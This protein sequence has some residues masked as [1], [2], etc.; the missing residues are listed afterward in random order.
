MGA[1]PPPDVSTES[2]T[3][4]Q[5]TKEEVETPAD[6]STKLHPEEEENKEAKTIVD[7][8]E[9]LSKEQK[10]KE[11][12]DAPADASE[13][14]SIELEG[15]SKAAETSNELHAPK[16]KIRKVL[17]PRSKIAKKS[18]ANNSLNKKK[19]KVT[20]AELEGEEEINKKGVLLINNGN[21]S[22]EEDT[23]EALC[24]E[25]ENKEE[26]KSAAD[27]STEPH[28]KELKTKN[29]V[30]ETSNELPARH[31]N[32]EEIQAAP[33][34]SSEPHSVE[35][36]NKSESARTSDKLQ[37]PKKK[38][39]KV[40]KARSKIAK[41]SPAI[42]SS[43][44]KKV[45]AAKPKVEVEKATKEKDVLSVKNG[46][47]SKEDSL[48]QSTSGDKMQRNA[49]DFRTEGKDNRNL[50]GKNSCSH[51]EK[52]PKEPAAD[53]S[54]EKRAAVIGKSK[55]KWKE[56][57]EQKSNKSLNNLKDNEKPDNLEKKPR[58]EKKEKLGGL[59]FMCNSK[60]K[61]DCLRYGVMGVS[62]NKKDLVLSVRP[63]LKLFLYDY[64]LKL[65][66]GIY[67]A[68]SP[69]GMRLEP[70]AFD[71][72]FPVQV[73]FKVHLDCYPLP[74]NIF[75]KGMEENFT[76]KHK[77]KTELSSKQVSR[78]AALF[79]SIELH[80]K[81]LP[82]RSP[83]LTGSRTGDSHVR[84]RESRHLSHRETSTR[85]SFADHQSRRLPVL[86]HERDRP[87]VDR[88]LAPRQ[89]TE[90]RDMYLTEQEYR[91]FGLRGERRNSDLPRHISP[92]LRPYREDHERERVR[93]LPEELR[94]EA[95]P[96]PRE[97]AVRRS[98]TSDREYRT[99]SLHPRQELHYQVPPSRSGTSAAAAFDSYREDPYDAYRHGAA[100]VD[101]Y[102]HRSRREDI[103]SSSFYVGS[104]RESYSSEKDHL[105]RREV[106]RDES[107]PRSI[108]DLLGHDRAHHYGINENNASS[109]PVS[110][111]Y[112]FAGPR[113]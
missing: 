91:A 69:G 96:A 48:K 52:N 3:L 14:H 76:T 85:D 27:V 68:T 106:D 24:M 44:K 90:S 108:D 92:T 42:A 22:K 101:P 50:K 36:K 82:A 55:R 31:K 62:L 110:S 83:R 66:Y 87:V 88:E 40:L 71:G 34:V 95:A 18:P 67:K 28:S 23:T 12:N 72:A 10:R 113:I 35:L 79:R 78:L 7:S 26:T 58:K 84:A 61:P 63:G 51:V 100:S 25:Q 33:D 17:T 75:K 102:A 73:R 109:L 2:H 30:A 46:N 57:V 104:R 60:T 19:A 4:E 21:G 86:A 15:K 81:E 13:P 98:Y 53:H 8:T 9:P 64:D 29:K 32:V 20:V 112:S 94:R 59:I 39:V 16:K 11:D 37:A 47:S 38:T 74:E 89:R 49:D 56:T 54:E 107:H 5:E 93:R 43:M 6:F 97:Y 80:P 77:F 111:R 41:K 103:P 1:E 65:M 45:E 99:Y 105:R 70:R